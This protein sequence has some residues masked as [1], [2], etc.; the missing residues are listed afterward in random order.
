MVASGLS[1]LP[2]GTSERPTENVVVHLELWA[3]RASEAFRFHE[4]LVP[5]T[6]SDDTWAV[7][8]KPTPPRS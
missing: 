7:W 3:A 2:L 1:G 4:T 5:T 8:I 6:P